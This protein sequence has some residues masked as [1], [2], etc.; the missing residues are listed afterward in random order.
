MRNQFCLFLLFLLLFSCKKDK[1]PITAVWTLN[2]IKSPAGESGEP[3]LFATPNGQLYLSWVEYADDTTD[4]LQFSRFNNGAWS[5]PATIAKGGDWFVN[6]ADFPSLAVYPDGNHLAAHYLAKS[7]NG[8]YDYDVH[9][10]QSSDGGAHWSESFILHTDGIPAEHGFVSLMPIETDRMFAAWLDGRNTK[11]EGGTMTLRTAL[12]DPKGEL[13][14]EAELDNKVCDCCQTDAVITESGP[15]V[16]YRDRSD[17]EIRDIAIV[18]KVNGQWTKPQLVY[19]DNWHIA[20]CPVNGPAVAAAGKKIAVAWFTAANEKPMVKLSF[21]SDSGATFDEPIQID[22]GDPL[23]RVDVLMTKDG[24]T[25]V[26]WME[27]PGEVAE[28]KAV[29]FDAQLNQSEPVIIGKNAA[30]RASGFPILAAA[31]DAVYVA[32]TQVDS[33]S[34]H[35]KT[36]RFGWQ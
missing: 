33:L 25:V 32:W 24:T 29:K 18:R 9:I 14:E 4:V 34:T 28:I 35:V 12:F 8:T 23:G 22:N 15:V 16:V 21:S 27:A 13:F 11:T 31:N 3:N 26:S 30:S 10:T 6:W 36:A 2:E 7:A 1:E 19:A 17:E 5:T 20:G